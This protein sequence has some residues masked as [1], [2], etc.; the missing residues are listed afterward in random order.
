MLPILAHIFTLDEFEFDR[1]RDDLLLMCFAEKTADR[2]AALSSVIEREVIHVHA[3][4]TVGTARVETARKLHGIRQCFVAMI[5]S[6]LDAFFD[7]FRN[8]L[9]RFLAEI[10]L[11][12]IAAER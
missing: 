12:D 1:R 7:V 11:D 6:I 10:A 5:E 4:E 8:A 9:D 3:D 2:F